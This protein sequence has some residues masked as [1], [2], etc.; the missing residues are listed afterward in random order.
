M[1]LLQERAR[2][3]TPPDL[4][5]LDQNEW[6]TPQVTNGKEPDALDG[7]EGAEWA[8]VAFRVKFDVRQKQ[9]MVRAVGQ[10]IGF[11]C[12]TLSHWNGRLGNQKQQQ[13]TELPPNTS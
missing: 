8:D 3:T 1:P 6:P 7:K 5:P 2:T 9:L 10:Q 12:V 11:W 13:Q 4:T